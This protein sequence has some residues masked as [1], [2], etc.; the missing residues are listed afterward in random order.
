MRR[1]ASGRK[2]PTESDMVDRKQKPETLRAVGYDDIRALVFAD[3][4]MDIGPE[5]QEIKPLKSTP[6]VEMLRSVAAR[7]QTER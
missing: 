5:T 3:C 6:F 1:G 2:T 7:R 4:G